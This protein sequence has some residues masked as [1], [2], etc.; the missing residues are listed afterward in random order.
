MPKERPVWGHSQIVTRRKGTTRVQCR[1]GKQSGVT[2]DNGAAEWIIAHR[3]SYGLEE[4]PV[5]R[6]R[7]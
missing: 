4:R 2:D 7:A 3:R 6:R 5:G 1:C